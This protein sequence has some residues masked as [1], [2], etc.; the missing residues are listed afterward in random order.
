MTSMIAVVALVKLPISL[1]FGMVALRGTSILAVLHVS[2]VGPAGLCASSP[3]NFQ[4]S[5]FIP[6][7][8]AITVV[9]LFLPLISYLSCTEVN[10][11]VPFSPFF[12]YFVA[13]GTRTS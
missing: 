8:E 13:N 5:V 2:V 4:K 12:K 9:L 10:C 6:S 7:L 11:F 1:D 3:S